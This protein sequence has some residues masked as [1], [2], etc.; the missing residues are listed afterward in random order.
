M[1]TRALSVPVCE[2]AVCVELRESSA[3][4]APTAYTL[5]SPRPVRYTLRQSARPE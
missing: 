4:P 2:V 3:P 1:A 5:Q